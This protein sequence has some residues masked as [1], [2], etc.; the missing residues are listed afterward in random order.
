M[1][2][3]VTIQSWEASGA[4]SRKSSAGV[5]ACINHGTP[6]VSQGAFLKNRPLDPQKT[7]NY[8]RHYCTFNN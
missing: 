8:F 1:E 5:L 4:G 6:A 7:F 2:L 3:V